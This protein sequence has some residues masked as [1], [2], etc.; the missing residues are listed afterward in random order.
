[1]AEDLVDARVVAGHLGVS[2]DWVYLAA[3]R[4]R[5]PGYRAGN[6]WRFRISEVETALAKPADR[7]EEPDL[8]AL[9]GPRRRRR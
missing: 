5:L 1:M 8:S 3:A 4:G 6:R 7:A 9:L 2:R